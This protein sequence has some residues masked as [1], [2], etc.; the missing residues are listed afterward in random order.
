FYIYNASSQQPGRAVEYTLSPL[1]FESEKLPEPG[2]ALVD[3]A[4]FKLSVFV[5]PGSRKTGQIT[6]DESIWAFD[7]PGIRPPIQTAFKALLSGIQSLEG[8][9]V[10]PGAFNLIRQIVAAVTP[11][12]F[13]ESLYF[14]YSL[15]N[16]T[17]SSLRS[18]VDLQAGM[19]LRIDFQSSQFVTPPSTGGSETF[20]PLV[21]GYVGG[22]QA[23]IHL[24]DSPTKEGMPRLR[25]DAFVAEAVL[26]KVAANTGGAGG[27]VDLKN[28]VYR[29][30]FFRICMPPSFPSSDSSG[31]VGIAQN[32]TLL[33]ADTL[34]ALEKATDAYYSSEP[35]PTDAVS[36]FFRGRSVL[37]PEVPVFLNG[38]STYLPIGT[39]L[40]QFLGRYFEVPR[41]P[42]LN[43]QQNSNGFS[44]TRLQPTA[45]FDS[46]GFPEYYRGV[47]LA[48][49]N[50]IVDVD[51]LD[52]PI[53]ASDALML[54]IPYG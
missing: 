12:S 25:F 7:G 32:I 29:R 45:H 11:S 15:L 39:T 52:L 9:G 23:L 54:G 6:I 49:V 31:F 42:G 8:G 28:S 20:N 1:A 34:T 2:T 17:S 26:P 4:P 50:K 53:L 13:A 10:V 44:F 51:S 43:L 27:I 30:R 33:G 46:G 14:N 35:I 47:G 16:Q 37:T 36:A 41:L 48:A 38:R 19:R 40:R 18:Q 5:Q 22:A 3:A 24:V 21:N